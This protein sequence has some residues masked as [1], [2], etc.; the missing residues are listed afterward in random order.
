[1]RQ[2]FFVS[3]THCSIYK[4]LACSLLVQNVVSILLSFAIFHYSPSFAMLGP[5][6][7]VR[8]RTVSNQVVVKSLTGSVVV[9]VS[10]L[11]ALITYERLLALATS[12]K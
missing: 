2:L 11:G 12:K 5:N 4:R 6:H 9:G 10:A 7:I 3:L 8:H 1:M